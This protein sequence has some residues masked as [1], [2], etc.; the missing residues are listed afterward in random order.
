VV[1][2]PDYKIY[3]SC[4]NIEFYNT[5]SDSTYPMDINIRDATNSGFDIELINHIRDNV[6]L[7]VVASRGGGKVEHFSEVFE[8]NR[9]EAALAAGIFHM[10]EVPIGAVK[11]ICGRKG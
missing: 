7:P 11:E 8:N 2:N 1:K 3:I 10:E 5:K 6:S 4:H 9:A